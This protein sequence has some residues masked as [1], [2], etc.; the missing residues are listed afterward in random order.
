MMS[1]SPGAAFLLFLTTMLILV[2][3]SSVRWMQHAGKME[4]RVETERERRLSVES[5]YEAQRR[6]AM[7]L[8][9][10]LRQAGQGDTS[11]AASQQG[12]V[13]YEGSTMMTTVQI[14]RWPFEENFLHLCKDSRLRW[15]RKLADGESPHPTAIV[16]EAKDGLLAGAP[17]LVG[18]P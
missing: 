1:Y 2:S 8:G 11:A 12:S 13:R 6:K 7:D 3:W 5:M 18:R 10:K 9:Q 14:A 4:L 17:S 16:F 15:S